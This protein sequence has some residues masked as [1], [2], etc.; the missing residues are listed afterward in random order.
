MRAKMILFVPVIK[1]NNHQEE[2]SHS[3][4]GDMS[5]ETRSVNQTSFVGYAILHLVS[6]V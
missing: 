2:R 3:K 1:P 6:L 4:F 5:K